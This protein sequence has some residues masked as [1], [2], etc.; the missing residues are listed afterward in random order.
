LTLN[1]S[2]GLISGTP[3][4]PVT[5]AALTFKVTDSGS[6][7]Q[8]A[9]A[10]LSL[11]IAPAVLVITTS[12]LPNGQAG[13][14]Y[15]QTL[16]ATGGTGAYTWQLT[17]GTLPTGL[18]LT[19]STGLI[20]GTPSV[21]ITATPLTFKV[22]DSA[23]TPQ[24]ATANLTLTIAPPLLTITT[25]SLVSGQ[26]G[27][28]YSQT[29]AATGG[30]GAYT[31][32]LTAGTLPTGLTLNA[33]SGLISGTPST[34]VSATPLTFKV[35]DSGSPA[36]TAT[37]TNLTLTIAPAT[38]TITTAS[39]ASGQVNVTYSLTL[40]ATGGTGTYTWQLTAGTLP[41]GLSL[42]AT[43][44][45]ISGTPTTQVTTTPLTFKVM[46]SG[47]PVQTAS[48]NFTLT[49]APALLTITTTSLPNGQA[50]SAYSQTLAATGGT[51]AYTWQLTAGT[52]PTGLTLNASSGL[53]SGTP[54]VPVT[55]T[56][57]FKVTDSG[58]PTPQTATATLTL[59]IAP[60]P[61][62]ITTASLPNGQ[63]LSAYSQTLAA[64]GGTG[65]F[66][67]QLTAGTLPTGLALNASSGL[68]S[69]TPTL[70]VTATSLTFKVT[71]S[72]SPAQ[73]TSAS[74]TLT[75]AP[76]VL[77]ITTT[78]LPNG[79]ALSAYSQTL[80][81]TGGTGA[82]TW[83][84]TAGTLPT[85]LTLNASSGL[86]GGT[87]TLPVTATSLTFKVTDSGSPV[88]TATA[89]LTL[90]IA[91][92]PLLIT[93]ASLP[94]GIQGVGYSQTLAAT[95]GTGAYTWQL[96][97]GTLPAGLALTAASG[98]I[99][100][101]PSAVVSATPLTFKVTDS[102]SPAKNAS[103]NLT[104][105]IAPPTLSITT[106][107]LATGA[108][109]SPYTQTL[110]AT[111]GTGSYSWQVISGTLP[112][113]LVLHAATGQISGT[114]TAPANLTPLG[115]K[116]TDSGSPA[117]TAT[118]ILTM[119]IVALNLSITTP[120]PLPGGIA[121][122]PYSATVTATGG[123]AP[124]T[125]AASG[126]PSGLGMNAAGQIVGTPLGLSTST[127]TVTVTDSTTPTA[128]TAQAVFSLTI[129]RLLIIQTTSLPDATAGAPYNTTMTATGGVQPY[130]WSASNLPAGLLMNTS[131]IIT[132]T[133][134]A[135]SAS[136]TVTV[137][138]S[139]S[140]GQQ[141]A[142]LVLNLNV[143][144]GASGTF[145]VDS[146]SVGN[147]LQGLVNI[148]IAP[149]VAPQGG[150]P[151]TLTSG[152][153]N[154]LVMNGQSGLT[155]QITASIGAGQSSIAV[156]VQALSG[157][158]TVQLMA[159]A[160][161][162][163]GQGTITLTP[164][165]FILTAG[166]SNS[167]IGSFTANQGSQTMLTVASA[168]LDSNFNFKEF[169]PVRVGF[170]TAVTLSNTSSSVGS[171][172][173]TFVTFNGG[174]SS[175]QT[176]FT[177]KNTGSTN[178][179]SAT[180][181]A[182]VPTGFS[183][184]AANA[185]SVTAFINGAGIL[186]CNTTV[187]NNLEAACNIT[188]SGTASS[189]LNITLTSNDT[190]KLLLSNTP[191]GVGMNQITV[192]VNTNSNRS[193]TFYVFG[194]ASTG[195]ATYNAAANGFGTAAGTVNLAPSGFILSSANGPGA[196]FFTFPST[197]VGVTVSSALLSSTGDFS[198]TQNVAGGLSFNINVTATDIAPAS[199]VG[200]L[201]PPQLTIAGGVGS[202]VSVFQP[203][204]TGYTTLAVV[205]PSGFGFTTP[206]Q[207]TSLVAQ[208]KGQGMNVFYNGQ[209]G[210]HLQ[211]A[212]SL[213]LGA[214]PANPVQ[215]T[216]TSNDPNLSVAPDPTGLGL[217]CTAAGSNQVT[218]TITPPARSGSF[219]FYGLASSGSPTFT[220]AAPG[221]T[222]YTGTEGLSPSAVLIAYNY[223][224]SVTTSVSAGNLTMTVYTAALTADLTGLVQFPQ[225]V[226]G[227]FPIVVPLG[228]S[229]P[230]AGTL[231][232]PN[233]QSVTF[234]AGDSS[235]DIVFTP[236]APGGLTNISV[237]APTNF[238]V[239]NGYGFVAVNVLNQ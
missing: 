151:L 194:L 133:T 232:D 82:Y 77:T 28:A 128:F 215:V 180:L 132:G 219:C 155:S 141:T 159:A 157:T 118:T 197:P 112:A 19:A 31:W 153:A 218:F 27:V 61:L 136:V 149:Q 89:N 100:G 168:R 135:G 134:T 51:G 43:T 96:T 79:Q 129:Q 209:V 11:T 95:G 220:V 63:A 165:A 222:T 199:G 192:T 224:N 225:Q 167:P 234:N 233:K 169:Q 67:W 183:L 24:V 214:V 6:P 13:V 195:T 193:S 238:N 103:V 26:V 156:Y 86:I 203:L 104:L 58:S 206:N 36:Q 70:P 60:A 120:S 59:T 221:F 64:T 93:T 65:A 44:G 45:L 158:G 185:N 226:A 55:A 15:S 10:N 176:V 111:G 184:P 174:D 160:T 146:I 212:A 121:G 17:A 216:I 7:A 42:N 148:S 50:L 35:T 235:H 147:N 196:S 8:T 23:S 187:G 114:P 101:T 173:P 175:Y 237:S 41:A 33:S 210:Y 152:N 150:L 1:A 91:P 52:L 25:T 2:S 122:V 227:G 83:Q 105:T 20:A 56:L 139:A 123:T 172:A 229:F 166:V 22:T 119:T 106:T 74:F 201:S 57:G 68:I 208:V 164:S 189:L 71:D 140:P 94:N 18:T 72:A 171:L 131:G 75:I 29:L 84:L 97:A 92:A 143:I 4:S 162:F 38:L 54:A 182:A 9:T 138:D 3:A 90:T 110:A 202:A 145:N 204:N 37:T 40:A 80:A 163:A 205:Q 16:T 191:D 117:Q 188:L 108:V 228:N 179:A 198:A 85:G 236:K 116:V 69:G 47:S 170:T 21:A 109:G 177:A 88:Q 66:T 124:Y 14:A 98:L 12:S 115:F 217:G 178:Q 200:T 46:D 48:G 207:Y 73:N 78:S 142:S 107:L 62:T 102:G 223:Q 230:T 211:D 130:S 144:G 49:I 39:L 76:A 231:N 125:W 127:V 5:A 190:S 34:P 87:P 181:T 186:P 53:I 126:L 161:N 30:T 213:L 113:G 81:A 137:S 239:Y 32:Q 99:S 154:L